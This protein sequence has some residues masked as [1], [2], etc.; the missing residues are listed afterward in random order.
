MISRRNWL[1][2]LAG[3]P[4]APALGVSLD[5]SRFLMKGEF[6]RVEAACSSYRFH[7]H[8]RFFGFRLAVP[9]F[10]GRI[11]YTDFGSFEC[12]GVDLV[13][14]HYHHLALTG[15][16]GETL[17]LSGGRLSLPVVQHPS[18][19]CCRLDYQDGAGRSLGVVL[20]FQEKQ[21]QVC[22][23]FEP[24][25]FAAREELKLA[26]PGRM[27]FDRSRQ[28]RTWASYFASGLNAGLAV[29][30][31][32]PGRISLAGAPPEKL[33]ICR[34]PADRP[35][36][37]LL[38]ILTADRAPA[39][40]QEAPA[41]GEMRPVRTSDLPSWETAAMASRRWR[42][43]A[44]G[45]KEKIAGLFI[46]AEGWRHPVSWLPES[47]V[48]YV[49]RTMLPKI[50]A[51]RCFDAVGFSRDGIT[52][53]GENLSWLRLVEDA[54]RAG[55]RVYMKPGDGELTAM[56]SH[57]EILAWARLCFDTAPEQR[58]D[59]VRLPGEAVLV[60]WVTPNLCLEPRF[61]SPEL[62]ELAG[63]KWPDVSRRIVTLV[64]DRFS[65]VIDA[66]RRYAP[67]VTIDLEC[68]DTRVLEVLL[69]RH[70][71][72]GVMYMAYGQ[73]PRAA[74]YLDL[75]E[76]VARLQMKARRVVLET[77]CYYSHEV[78]GLGQLK[79]KPYERLYSPADI[80]LMADKHR[81]MR[82]L[83]VDAVWAW[84]LNITWSESKFKAICDAYS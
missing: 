57:E 24:R 1:L 25:G 31:S 73:Y 80:R 32:E 45:A 43:A 21:P 13:C 54:H 17:Q 49:Q 44:G 26:L 78:T 8:G 42:P 83:A 20:R 48:A 61:I 50:A 64:A 52:E 15:G 16:S 79:S 27:I 12:G 62:R 76:C 23:R 58:C 37:W 34:I 66:I 46:S 77:D 22:I 3:T 65:W 74:Q 29:Q 72:L 67:P 9:P 39:E 4:Q 68:C 38:T 6:P 63:W 35:S 30:T 28:G 56:R 51:A 2:A 81:H 75:Y 19:P 47:R 59:A 14:A 11:T 7:A 82:R 33:L 55:L 18:A 71:N 40:A 84:G 69:S 10:D 5:A 36:G 60:P 41:T 70:A 53:R